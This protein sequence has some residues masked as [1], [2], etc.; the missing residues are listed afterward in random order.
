MKTKKRQNKFFL[1]K[2]TI[3]NLNNGDMV[4]I[5]GGINQQEPIAADSLIIC[6]YTHGPECIITST[7]TAHTC[8][9]A[10]CTPLA[11]PVEEKPYLDK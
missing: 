8:N 2:E 1:K 5:N 3:A 10:S 6:V 11:C 4:R 7:V 9:Q